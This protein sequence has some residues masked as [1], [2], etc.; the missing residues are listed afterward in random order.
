M[1]QK[2]GRLLEALRMGIFPAGLKAAAAI[3]GIC[4]SLMWKP[5]TGLTKTE[6]DLVK[7]KLS[8][9]ELV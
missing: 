9:L 3:Q 6:T 8:E 7:Q 4:S 1:Q 2:I 5:A